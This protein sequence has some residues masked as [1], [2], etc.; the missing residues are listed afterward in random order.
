MKVQSEGAFQKKVLADLK[1]LPQCDVLKTQERG[2]HG[3]PDII[4][5]LRGS[6]VAIEL[7]RE[8]KDA[9]K[10]QELKLLRI[11]HAQGLAFVA[12]PSTWPEQYKI[13]ENLKG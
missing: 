12:K 7:K 13:L 9:T 6:F 1:R 11:R 5:C 3:V 2:R 4:L 8:G 10:L